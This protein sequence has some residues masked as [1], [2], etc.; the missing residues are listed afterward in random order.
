MNNFKEAFYEFFTQIFAEKLQ[1]HTRNTS[2]EFTNKIAACDHVG[3][4]N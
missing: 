1:E 3:Q 2:F 4:R